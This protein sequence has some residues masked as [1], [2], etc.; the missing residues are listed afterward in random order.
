MSE[1]TASNLNPDI[2]RVTGGASG[3][4]EVI[5]IAP[6]GRLFWH[7]R[8]VETDDAFRGAMLEL[9]YRLVPKA[10]RA[11]LDAS[12]AKDAGHWTPSKE[13]EDRFPG[14]VTVSRAL[15]AEAYRGLK[16]TY[17]MP[18][19]RRAIDAAIERTGPHSKP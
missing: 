9:A 11:E 3:S 10:H 16:R 5:R 18:E 6:D 15:L 1:I 14:A 13:V 7:Q 8:E 12:D 19:V 4:E 2:I 17:E